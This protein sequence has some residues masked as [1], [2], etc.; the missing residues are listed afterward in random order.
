[1]PQLNMNDAIPKDI[2]AILLHVVNNQ[3]RPTAFA[4]RSLTPAEQ[5]YSQLDR[6]VLAIVF[7]THHFFTYLYEIHFKLITDNQLLTRIFH[8]NGKLP[9]I[10]SSEITPV[11][12]IFK[13]IRL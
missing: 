6:E 4:S 7:G 2:A 12:F 1:M 9:A 3:E 11:C 13:W 10:D 8:Q 5:N